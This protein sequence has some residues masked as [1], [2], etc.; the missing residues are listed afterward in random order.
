MANTPSSWTSL[1]NP[2]A[3][4]PKVMLR[5]G[6]GF[7]RGAYLGFSM[8]G[9]M[10]GLL[11]APLTGGFSFWVPLV[12]SLICGFWTAGVG[13]FSEHKMQST[14]KH[15]KDTHQQI[16]EQ[17][18]NLKQQ[19]SIPSLKAY[20][21]RKAKKEKYKRYLAHKVK[22]GENTD[23]VIETYSE[24]LQLRQ[25]LKKSAA[26]ELPPDP[27]LAKPRGFLG[28]IWF[29][30]ESGVE[31]FFEFMGGA[32][33]STRVAV[34]LIGLCGILT[35][36]QIATAGLFALLPPALFATVISFTLI[37]SVLN[38]YQYWMANR[39]E[40]K[41]K[42]LKCDKTRTKDEINYLEHQSGK[43]KSLTTLAQP[44]YSAPVS[45]AKD[46][47]VSS[48]APTPDPAPFSYNKKILAF[49]TGMGLVRGGY[50]GFSI[51]G[52]FAGVL[53]APLTGGFSFWLPI[54]IGV[55]CAAWVARGRFFLECK[56][57]RTAYH[58]QLKTQE[59]TLQL[60][61]LREE[62]KQYSDISPFP[63]REQATNKETD[64]KDTTSN[65]TKVYQFIVKKI[66]QFFDGL[67][68]A[69]DSARTILSIAGLAS[70]LS[71]LEVAK[72]GLL[73]V[74]VPLFCAFVPLILLYSALSIYQTKLVEDRDQQSEKLKEQRR[75]DKAEMQY[76]RCEI[77]ASKERLSLKKEQNGN[78]ATAFVENFAA[79]E[80][81]PPKATTFSM[82]AWFQSKLAWFTNKQGE[83]PGPLPYS[84]QTN[85]QNYLYT[86]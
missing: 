45:A 21:A 54:A 74:S 26:S 79:K 2:F 5:T 70:L 48:D 37:Y 71:T 28:S 80:V 61:E 42:Q 17:L 81:P 72:I 7:I 73:A 13:F 23:P 65:V 53:F 16:K 40:A 3:Y 62:A 64:D 34:G 35:G 66:H 84:G 19:Q 69:K 68:G 32:K 36:L 33:D 82:K 56:Q 60:A 38:I 85:E 78:Y 24:Y 57:Q 59:V 8:V 12:C 1:L 4:N 83:L 76:L 41:N 9:L 39:R 10:F 47:A 30:F 25:R 15:H 58:H 77:K 43:Y 50:L 22:K 49:R 55:F 46:V 11:L 20:L 6:M 75:L 67:G 63:L 86:P 31:Y 52:L 44:G 51:L 29:L 18:D 14:A 27:T